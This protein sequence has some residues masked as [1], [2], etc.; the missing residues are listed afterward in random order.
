MEYCYTFGSD[1][2]LKL[3]R[4]NQGF[5]YLILKQKETKIILMS[6]TWLVINS[7]LSIK[8][9]LVEV[10]CKDAEININV[11]SCFSFFY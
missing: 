11:V 4:S 1:I 5:S 3:F 7:L 2:F 9:N 10:G 8:V 6:T